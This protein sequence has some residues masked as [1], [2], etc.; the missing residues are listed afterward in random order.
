MRL[1]SASESSNHI[2][3]NDAHF[4]YQGKKIL[5]KS[6]KNTTQLGRINLHIP[7]IGHVKSRNPILQLRCI[8]EPYAIDTWFSTTI[9]Y[10]GYNCAH[11][12]YG[13]MS[14]F[15]SYYGLATESDGTNLLLDC[16]GSKVSH[17][18]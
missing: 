18:Q 3:E 6:F 10:E 5:I 11:I 8:N 9:G 1:T 12:F 7:M 14:K 4:L 15:I 16:L 17:Y 13:T 2:K